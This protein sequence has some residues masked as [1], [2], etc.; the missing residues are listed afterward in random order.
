MPNFIDLTGKR[1]GRLLVIRKTD[2]RRPN[3]NV[4]FEC[5]CDCGNTTYQCGYDLRT[6]AVYSCGCAR[7]DFLKNN[8]IHYKHGYWSERLHRVWLG[9]HERCE[10]PKHISYKNYGGRGITVCDEWK[11]YK[12][13]R[14]WAL[15]HG[16]DPKAPRGQ[17]TIDRIDNDGCYSPEN[18]RWISMSEQQNNKGRY[19]HAKV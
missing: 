12:P 18:C 1:F 4:V 15:S 11:E 13:F 6:G 8:P 2:K 7:T 10:N 17:C 3:G 9:M 16:Y 5:L 14:D 19:V